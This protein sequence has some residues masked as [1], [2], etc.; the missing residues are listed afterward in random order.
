MK[1]E[2]E[3]GRVREPALLKMGTSPDRQNFYANGSI[4]E[5]DK[6]I[7]ITIVQSVQSIQS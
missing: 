2:H 3:L 5:S 7:R 1:E 6:R 4:D